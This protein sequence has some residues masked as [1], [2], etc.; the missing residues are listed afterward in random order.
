M[1]VLKHGQKL[2]QRL[3][4]MNDTTTTVEL[5]KKLDTAGMTDDV[6]DESLEALIENARMIAVSDG[7]PKVKKLHGAEMPA[8][9]LAT[10]A[11]TLHLL[12]TQDGAG[13]GMTFEKVDVLENHYADTSCLKWLQRSPWGQLYW[14]LY[15]NYVGNLVKIRI[16]EH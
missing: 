13:S 8:L 3:S 4:S 9:D 15:K 6:P 12:A 1:M 10:R 16:I 5:I 7:F 14:R 11:M 2:R